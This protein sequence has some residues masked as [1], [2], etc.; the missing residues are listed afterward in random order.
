MCWGPGSPPWPPWPPWTGMPPWTMFIM[1]LMSR[2]CGHARWAPVKPGPRAP[3]RSGQPRSQ[4]ARWPVPATHREHGAVQHAALLQLLGHGLQNCRVHGQG[5]GAGHGSHG[6]QHGQH[7]SSPLAKAR[8]GRAGVKGWAKPGRTGLPGCNAVESTLAALTM[9]ALPGRGGPSEAGLRSCVE[10][11]PRAVCRPRTPTALHSA[12]APPTPAITVAT[13]Q[14][15]LPPP[16][17]A[18]AP[19]WLPLRRRPAAAPLLLRPG[20]RTARG[21]AAAPGRTAPA[22]VC[23]APQT[24]SSLARTSWWLRG[25][26]CKCRGVGRAAWRAAVA[27]PR[28]PHRQPCAP[29]IRPAPRT[30]P[31]HPGQQ[32]GWRWQLTQCNRLGNVWPGARPQHQQAS[33]PPQLSARRRGLHRARPRWRRADPP[34]IMSSVGHDMAAA[35]S[36]FSVLYFIHM[37]TVMR[38]PTAAAGRSAQ[39]RQAGVVSGRRAAA[40]PARAPRLPRLAHPTPA[41]KYHMSACKQPSSLSRKSRPS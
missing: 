31:G 33:P 25:R 39:L 41:V 27:A 21:H 3:R 15:C 16:A 1:L 8:R 36:G 29:T 35:N 28:R 23:S 4:A 38:R 40:R 10:A 11:G 14:P 30:L 2:F 26:G 32:Q 20:R 24:P 34:N 22:A 12:P 6:G 18:W 17:A 5:H 19:P 9:A 7:G 37:G 13:S